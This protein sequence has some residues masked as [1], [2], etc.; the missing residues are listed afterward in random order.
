LVVATIIETMKPTWKPTDLP[1]WKYT[2]LVV[3]GASV[4][5]ALV[6]YIVPLH[7]KQTKD[8]A[9]TVEAV[10]KIAARGGTLEIANAIDRNLLYRECMKR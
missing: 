8:E 2:L 4:S 3:F 1:P 5:L 7:P 6:D 9:C 10:K